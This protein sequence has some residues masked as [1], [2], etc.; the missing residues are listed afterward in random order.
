[1]HPEVDAARFRRLAMEFG[2]P[3]IRLHD[4]RHTSVSLKR[5][6]GWP[7]HLV[8]AWHGR[9]EAVMRA[10]YTHSYLADLRPHADAMP[11]RPPG[12]EGACHRACNRSVT[13]WPSEAFRASDE[14]ACLRAGP[15]VS[16]TNSRRPRLDSNQRPSD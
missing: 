2:V 13:G 4:T 6:Q 15:Q 10:T 3:A 12:S 16:G 9:D 5:T 8:A 7:D 14:G 1:M 11:R